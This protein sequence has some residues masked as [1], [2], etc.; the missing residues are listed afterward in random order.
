[1]DEP[2]PNPR[3]SCLS[4]ALL[5]VVAGA[6]V[7]AFVFGF[8]GPRAGSWTTIGAAALAAVAVFIIE[9]RLKNLFWAVL[10]ALVLSIHPQVR[11]PAKDQIE[12]LAQSGIL[13][14]LAAVAV[15]WHLAFHRRFAWRL[16]PLVGGAMMTSVGLTWVADTS[17]G[18]LA[19]LLIGLSLLPAAVFARYRRLRIDPSLPSRLNVL[20]TLGLAI[21]GPIGAIYLCRLLD[22]TSS[23]LR[24]GE[25]VRA[26]WLAFL[27]QPVNGLSLA[28]FN[29]WCW[30]SA[31]LAVPIL[32]WAWWR[33]LK[34]GWREWRVGHPPA[35]WLLSILA[36]LAAG[37]LVPR[38]DVAPLVLVGISV[39]LL[40]FWVADVWKG[41]MEQLIL[42][43][44]EAE[45]PP[46]TATPPPPAPAP[47]PAEPAPPPAEPKVEAER[48]DQPAEPKVEAERSDQPAVKQS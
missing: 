21:L 20:T 26:A 47:P 32:L 15:A 27:D 22:L 4:L 37:F 28:G 16:W 34:R 41:T 2:H 23:E 40:V 17:L 46:L 11:Q 14:G 39:L 25:T 38:P 1:M 35:A 5:L 29:R 48:S 13:A 10:A 3:F 30:P 31:W 33:A 8:L 36:V 6:V 42:L 9:R 43:P 19:A 7:F 18:L 24:L 12:L 45:R 44:P